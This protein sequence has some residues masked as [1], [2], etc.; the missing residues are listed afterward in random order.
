[1][2]NKW[3]LGL[4]LLAAGLL[5]SY[6][7]IELE[8]REVKQFRRNFDS[9]SISDGPY[10]FY[11][12]KDLIEKNIVAGKVEV[13]SLSA[14]AMPS[15]FKPA[16]SF[17]K[18][19]EKIAALSDIHGQYDLLIEIF[20]NNKIIDGNLKWAF[21]EGHLVIV[22]DI[23]DRGEKVTEILWFIYDLEKQA[24]EQ[25]GMV[26]YLLGNHEYMV[27]QNDLR[28]IN[29]KY[30]TSAALLGTTYQE[31]FN[32][33]TVLGRW[34]RSKNT[35]VLIDD[36]LFVH[37]GISA[38]FVRSE[39]N[40]T[41]VKNLMRKS[42]DKPKDKLDPLVKELY[43]GYYGPIWY[44]GYFEDNLAESRIDSILMATDVKHI[45]VGHT[46]QERVE[47]LYHNKIFAVDSSIKLGKY[48]EILLISDGQYIRGTLK[49]EA[50]KFEN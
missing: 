23:F 17:F 50:I 2:K 1:M 10:I 16:K 36:N 22:G 3:I 27:M 14:D 45:V 30:Q 9:L 35:I 12:D 31:L 32:D 26:H 7:F 34:L 28:Y 38:E 40:P 11:S 42:I 48:G 15:K 46:S 13:K 8:N 24:L 25:G 49:G 18:K 43:F 29:E 4:S 44:R 20:K 5:L 21:G 37:G 6:S 33:Q 47:Q 19:V 41:Y 39:F